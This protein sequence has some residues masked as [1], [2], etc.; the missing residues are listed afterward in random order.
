MKFNRGLMLMT[1]YKLL[2]DMNSFLCYA[3][4]QRAIFCKSATCITLSMD[5]L[6]YA[7]HQED[8]LLIV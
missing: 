4:Y 7:T 1:L 2:C 6:N 3:P 5:R 8:A